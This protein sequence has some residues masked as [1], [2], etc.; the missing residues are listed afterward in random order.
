MKHE[1]IA[2][3]VSSLAVWCASAVPAGAQCDSFTFAAGFQPTGT[4]PA[5]VAFG[6]I[7]GDGLVDLAVSDSTDQSVALLFGTGEGS[8]APAVPL[9]G[10]SVPR[11]V[12]LGD[13]DGD[14]DLDLAVCNYGYND[15]QGWHDFGMTM[16]WNEGG[17]VFS[18]S[19]VPLAAGLVQPSD[20]AL[21]DLDGDLD[22]DAV[23]SLRGT[24]YPQS[25]VASFVNDGLGT[26]TGTPAAATGYDP[27]AIALGDL[28]LDGDLDAVTGNYLGDSF[29]VLRGNGDGTFGIGYSYSTT[30]VHD[31]A[32]GDIDRDGDPDVAVA[33]RY[34]VL[35][36]SNAGGNLSWL[37]TLSSGLYPTGV[38][39]SDLDGDLDQDLVTLDQ[40]GDMLYAWIGDGA[41]AFTL[42][43][44]LAVGDGPVAAAAHDFDADGDPDLGVALLSAGG[45][46]LLRSDCPLSTYCVG[47]VNSL[48]C[49]PA[50]GWTG[51]PAIGANDFHVVASDELNNRMGLAF[52][53]VGPVAKS[54]KG[55]TLCVK[56]PFV[57]TPAQDSGGS[58][59]GVDCSGTYDF[60]MTPAWLAKHG[61][62]AGDELFV[63]YWSRDGQNPDGTG[64]ALSNALR[65]TLL[66]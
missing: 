49:T 17:R 21:G 2:L 22:L 50:I 63:Q 33:Y 53:G 47:K 52:F 43:M 24:S 25:R 64:A 34:G 46:A 51:T 4:G 59:V 35:V 6:D 1:V 36:M 66:P 44:Q 5:A 11:A 15:A 45:V 55:G 12:A 40:F 13:L 31:V 57:R 37:A 26:F 16:L 62:G 9:P 54:F 65:F 38:A 14:A 58:S 60:D 48:G 28:D 41:G 27:V 18:S 23:L 10:G 61:W 30:Y 56:A 8:F 29:S 42:R 19:F 3:A 32:L 39:F 7:D 20:I